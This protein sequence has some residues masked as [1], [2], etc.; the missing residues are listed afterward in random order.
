MMVN[1]RHP[2]AHHRVAL[3]L[4]PCLEPSLWPVVVIRRCSLRKRL[5]TIALTF[6]PATLPDQSQACAPETRVIS[7][8]SPKF[9]FVKNWV[10]I[11]T[12]SAWR[13]FLS[14][15]PSSNLLNSHQN[16]LY[17]FVRAAVTIYHRLGGLTTEI[18][19]LTV[20]EARDL[21]SRCLSVGVGSSRRLKNLTHASSPCFQWFA[22]IFGMPWLWEA[23]PQSLPLSSYDIL[24]LYMSLCPN[25]P[26]YIRIWVTSAHPND[27][28]VANYIFSDL[29]SK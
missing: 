14:F 4:F 19:S 17:Q 24:P 26:L 13:T 29:I 10:S 16:C 11:S 12:P 20:L 7:Q 18:H 8:C 22:E 6:S 5:F 3:V 21:K 27:L 25:F 9:I 2:W 1:T 23:S 15:H 28:T